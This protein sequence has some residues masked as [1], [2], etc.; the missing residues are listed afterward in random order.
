M[1]S[2]AVNSWNMSI[3]H[4]AQCFADV[5]GVTA[6]TARKWVATYYNVDQD[7]LNDLLS[8]EKG[9]APQI[10]YCTIRS[11]VFMCATTSMKMHTNEANRI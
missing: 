5:C 9:G 4:A 2:T 3:L 7:F 10:V 6:H 8:S 11:F 1:F